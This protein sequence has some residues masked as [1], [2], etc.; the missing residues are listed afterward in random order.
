MAKISLMN[1]GVAAPAQ[2]GGVAR[3]QLLRMAGLGLAA[4]AAG[5]AMSVV[6]SSPAQARQHLWRYC[7]QCRGMWFSG[8]GNNGY[9]PVGSGFLGLDHSHQTAGS[10]DYSLKAEA[11]GGA[12]EAGWRW[13]YRCAGLWS[14][15]WSF[16][17]RTGNACPNAGTPAGSHMFLG[18]GGYLLEFVP[19]GTDGPG[20]QTAWFVCVKCAGLFF[21]GDNVLGVCP[22]GNTHIFSRDVGHD[23]LL[24]GV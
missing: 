11:D 2:A 8:N 21:G 23:Y 17:G 13:C 12:G 1:T 24:R 5:A 4:G 16:P 7:R 6:A 19:D 9:C 3:R 15:T 14:L 22:A 10:G 20:G 18:S